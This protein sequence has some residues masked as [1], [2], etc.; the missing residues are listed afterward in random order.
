MEIGKKL[1][2]GVYIL[3][4]FYFENHPISLLIKNG[5]W[6]VVGMAMGVGARIGAW[7]FLKKRREEKEINS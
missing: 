6:R 2:P 1:S 7:M 3:F 5:A 4:V